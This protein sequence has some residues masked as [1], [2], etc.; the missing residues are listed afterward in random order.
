MSACLCRLLGC[1]KK[2]KKKDPEATSS[3]STRCSPDKQSEIDLEKISLRKI[4]I[5]THRG[6]AGVSTSLKDVETVH[7]APKQGR[8]GLLVEF[9]REGGK[10]FSQI[11][12]VDGGEQDSG[13]QAARFASQKLSFSIGSLPVLAREFA[14]DNGSQILLAGYSVPSEWST[15]DAVA[16]FRQGR[17]HWKAEALSGLLL[18]RL[19]GVSVLA[20]NTSVV[21]SGNVVVVRVASLGL[22]VDYMVASKLQRRFFECSPTS[23]IKA[24]RMVDC[25]IELS[26]ASCSR[27]QFC[28]SCR[29][30]VWV[31]SEGFKDKTPKR[32]VWLLQGESDSEVQPSSAYWLAGFTVKCAQLEERPQ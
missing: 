23:E 11:I 20:E 3:T 13:M 18:R 14:I 24:G 27:Y 2:Q 30:G 15:G 10:V 7:P 4:E 8:P 9:S 32:G 16:E 12:R 29:D 19:E 22:E 6:S 5:L 25:D 26:G 17:F 31:I 28:I 21:C 1:V